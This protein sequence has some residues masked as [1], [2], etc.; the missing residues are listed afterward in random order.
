MSFT[1]LDSSLTASSIWGEPD[2]VRIVWVTMLS[3]A[4]KDGNVKGSIPGLAN[5]ARKTIPETESALAVLMAPDK[6]SGRPEMEGRRIVQIAGGW[7]LVTHSFY[8]ENGMSEDRKERT[9]EKTKE[10]VKR[11][12]ALHCVS[13]ASASDLICTASVKKKGSAEGKKKCTQAEAEAFCVSLGL[14]GSDGTAMFLHWEEKGWAKIKDW[15]LTIRKWQSFGY[16]PSQRKSGSNGSRPLSY[17]E[18]QKKLEAIND[19]L[20]QLY[21]TGDGKDPESMKLKEERTKLKEMI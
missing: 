9:R 16:L 21:R 20:N 19:R 17:F 18:K 7:H 8:R 11:Y 13:P 15:Q 14:P 5:L 10:R 2:S 4:D 6:Y 12:R 3:M 1:K